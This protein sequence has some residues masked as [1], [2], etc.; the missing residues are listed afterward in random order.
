MA[1]KKDN[2]NS[3]A[4]DDLFNALLKDV[5]DIK[6]SSTDDE[7]SL[8]EDTAF[9][10]P[11]DMVKS[12]VL[13]PDFGENADRYSANPS[14]RITFEETLMKD[15]NNFWEAAGKFSDNKSEISFSKIPKDIGLQQPQEK[16]NGPSAEDNFLDQIKFNID[17]NIEGNPLSA[18]PF[19]DLGLRSHLPSN[20]FSQMKTEIDE[21][22]KATIVSPK[23]DLVQPKM[24]GTEVMMSLV[25]PT[26]VSKDQLPQFKNDV[27][28]TIA[29]TKFAQKQKRHLQEQN[30]EPVVEKE[31]KVF[32]GTQKNFKGNSSQVSID[33]SLYQAENLRI[34]QNRILDL[35]KEIER[36][37]QENDEIITAAEIIRNK[38]EEYTIK[39]SNLE[40]E[41]QDIK[42]ESK[43]ELM[44]LKGSLLYKDSE[45]SKL[46]EKIEELELRIKTDFK[47]IRIRERELENRL[48]LLKAEKQAVIKSKDELLLELQR[49]NDISKAEIETYRNKVQE[50][51]KTIESYQN[52]IKLTVRTLRLALSHVDEKSESQPIQY[53]KAT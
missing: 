19:T 15:E 33:A 14:S 17:K 16:Y 6:D 5:E 37:R 1:G 50:L 31:E 10:V 24:D 47:K 27:D 30:L 18:N 21:N 29:V 11:P 51:N 2:N 45:N 25:E 9:G 28:K 32:I 35:E 34:A 53:K 7:S 49:K 46:K 3:T 36:L 12:E 42:T 38:A 41:N 8:L 43:N 23:N 48:E 20:N 13:I 44:I 40:R 39:I 22:N 4:S 52:Q 26:E